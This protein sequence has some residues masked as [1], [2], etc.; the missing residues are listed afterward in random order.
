MPATIS[1]CCR[2]GG[3]CLASTREMLSPT[4]C[5]PRWS[6]HSRASLWRAALD[7]TIAST[8]ADI[9]MMLLLTL[10]FVVAQLSLVFS[11]HHAV[12]SALWHLA[13]LGRFDWRALTVRTTRLGFLH[14]ENGDQINSVRRFFAGL[15]L[16]GLEDPHAANRRRR[17]ITMSLSGEALTRS[18]ALRSAP[19]SR[20]GHGRT[21]RARAA[22]AGLPLSGS[23]QP[24]QSAVHHLSSH[25]RGARAAG[26]HELGP[27]HGRLS[28]RH[29]DLARAVLHG[30][31]E[32]DAGRE[33]APKW[34]D[35]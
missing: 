15:G 27:V 14:S 16:G 7:H 32:S 20:V 11:G 23:D 2:S 17:V 26:R 1:G 33:S 22:S 35:T 30:V 21:Q 8:L 12:H 31:G 28:T 6:S 24:L 10:L 29:P 19:L 5:W 34:S 3:L 18:R 4:C 13:E 25:L 9:N